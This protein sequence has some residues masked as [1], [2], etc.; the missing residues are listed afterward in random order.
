MQFAK[1]RRQRFDELFLL[2]LIKA[3]P[4]IEQEIDE[5]AAVDFLSH[6]K[7]P[8]F[9]AAAGIGAPRGGAISLDAVVQ[10]G[11]CVAPL[12]LGLRT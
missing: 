9:D 1:K 8:T 5:A 4:L 11:V 3:I 6:K 10:Q 12:Q 2:G 7:R